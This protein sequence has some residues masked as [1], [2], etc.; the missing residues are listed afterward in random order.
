MAYD[1][2]YWRDEL[3]RYDEQYRKFDEAGKK[4]LKRY[5]DERKDS[6]NIEARFNI[7]WSNIRTLKPAIYSRVPKVEVS[8]RF[9]DRN[10]VARV[11][12]MILERAIDYELK[13]YSDYHSSLSHALDDRLLP[14]DL[15]HQV[16]RRVVLAD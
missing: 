4:I 15:R 14:G 2:L 3:K 6:E 12:S 5:R 7:L 16:R 8:R 10:D 11:A 9:K 13:Q 1:A